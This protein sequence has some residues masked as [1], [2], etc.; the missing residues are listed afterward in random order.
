M[1]EVQIGQETTDPMQVYQDEVAMSERFD[2]LY[3]CLSQIGPGEATRMVT[4][5]GGLDCILERGMDG[6]FGLIEGGRTKGSRLIAK[7]AMP[8]EFAP[9]PSEADQ[10]RA[11][12]IIKAYKLGIDLQ[13]LKIT[14]DSEEVVTYPRVKVIP[15]IVTIAQPYEPIVGEYQTVPVDWIGGSFDVLVAKPKTLKPQTFK[16]ATH[17]ETLE[18]IAQVESLF[19]PR[20]KDTGSIETIIADYP[21]CTFIDTDSIWGIDDPS[22]KLTEVGGGN[23]GDVLRWFLEPKKSGVK[24]YYE[25]NEQG[26]YRF[27]AYEDDTTT[28]ILYDSI[29]DLRTITS[30]LPRVGY[31]DP[32]ITEALRTGEKP[33]VESY[34]GDFCDVFESLYYGISASDDLKIYIDRIRSEPNFL[35]FMNHPIINKTIEYFGSEKFRGFKILLRK[36]TY[37]IIMRNSD[38]IINV[39]LYDK[40][41]R[42]PISDMLDGIVGEVYPLYRIMLAFTD[43][44]NENLKACEK[45]MRRLGIDPMRII[46][47]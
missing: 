25:I 43:E 20:Q 4:N 22:I 21:K 35:K 47:Q 41:A 44:L 2:R 7:F 37:E 45:V 9:V 17:Q 42:L 18:F 26:V 11:H 24:I 33:I 10:T 8:I 12:E 32:R 36:A 38:N 40:H 16:R 34:L 3:R 23:K 46:G 13:R 15:P 6:S 5:D 27:A 30:L 29:D 28:E 31:G 1:V 39:D 14:Q 19:V